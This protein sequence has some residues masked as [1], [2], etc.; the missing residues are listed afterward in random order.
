LKALNNPPALVKDVMEALLY[1]RD[2]NVYEWGEIK[3]EL[4]NPR[5]FMEELYSM[6][7]NAQMN[8]RTVRKL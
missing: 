2:M 4:K 6:D 7:F 1:V 3:K 8:Q 5:Q